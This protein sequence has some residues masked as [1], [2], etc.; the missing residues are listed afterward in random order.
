MFLWHFPFPT[1]RDPRLPGAPCP[2]EFGLSYPIADRID[3]P[4][5]SLT[6]TSLPVKQR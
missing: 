3:R 5:P 6:F 4:V 1:D 2:V